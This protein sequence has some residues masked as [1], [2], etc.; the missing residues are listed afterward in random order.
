MNTL[1]H[2]IV[3]VSDMEKSSAFYRGVLGFSP[4]HQSQK[5][6]AFDTGGV[7]LAPHL[8]DAAGRP[9]T[10]ATMPAGHCHVGLTAS[11][12]AFHTEMVAKGVTC[13]QPPKEEHFGR[14]A[15][16]ADPDGQPFSVSEEEQPRRT[17]GKIQET[18]EKVIVR[19]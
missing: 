18:D 4:T 3:F 14:L 19:Q 5:W 2:V 7:T 8:A 6:T 17:F 16:Y 13:S 15:I 11:L 12:D 1:G 10:H 9:H